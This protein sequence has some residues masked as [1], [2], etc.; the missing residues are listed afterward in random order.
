MIQE[1]NAKLRDAQSVGS[2]YLKGFSNTNG[3]TDYMY[4]PHI[5]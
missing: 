1:A 4:V 3:V 5:E 2:V